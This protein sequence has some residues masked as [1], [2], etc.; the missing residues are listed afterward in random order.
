MVCLLS[1]VGSGCIYDADDRCGAHQHYEKGACL[2]DEGTRQNDYRNGCVPCGVNEVGVANACTC[3]PGFGRPT[4]GGACEP[5]SAGL[6]KS[7]SE[8]AQAC[9]DEKYPACFAP[10]EGEPYCTREGCTS[11]AECGGGYAC[12]TGATPTVCVRLPTG[13]GTKCASDGE[14]AGFEANDCETYVLNICMVSGCNRD[15]VTCFAGSVCCDYSLVSL[16]VS[17]CIPRENLES[18]KCPLGGAIDAE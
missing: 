1:M 18:G 14:C 15:D 4:E 5:V 11:S 2:C 10:R 6:G 8:G 3:A 7:C 12:D 13:I 17:L 9:T 16:P